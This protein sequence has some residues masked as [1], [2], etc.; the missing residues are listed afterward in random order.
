M[1]KESRKITNIHTTLLLFYVDTRFLLKGL[2]GNGYRFVPR[3]GLF[4]TE[5]HHACCEKLRFVR[6]IYP[7]LP[8]IGQKFYHGMLMPLNES[9]VR[10]MNFRRFLD[11]Y[12]LKP[13]I[14][15]FCRQS[16]VP[17]CS[18]FIPIY[19][20][21][22]NHAPKDPDLIFLPIYMHWTMCM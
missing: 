17:W 20:M 12:N 10:F 13:G 6:S 2:R 9:M 4:P 21:G 7:N 15:M 3:G 1:S 18:K 5:N 22:P 11:Y 8:Q 19:C 14:S 16:T